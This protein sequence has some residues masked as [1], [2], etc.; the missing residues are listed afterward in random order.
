MKKEELARTEMGL[1]VME[2]K[3]EKKKRY[4]SK[5]KE[6]KGLNIPACLPKP[7]RRLAK[8]VI[9]GGFPARHGAGI[10]E[11]CHSRLK[12]RHGKPGNFHVRRLKQGN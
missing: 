10:V 11:S 12:T 8:R 3:K 7:A 2:G 6:D 9:K 4:E 1:N 5:G